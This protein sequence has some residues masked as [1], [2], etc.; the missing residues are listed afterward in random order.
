MF[1]GNKGMFKV[2]TKY[3]KAIEIIYTQILGSI[4]FLDEGAETYSGI[5]C[6]SNG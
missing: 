4:G 5:C 3:S 6:I 1:K 2:N